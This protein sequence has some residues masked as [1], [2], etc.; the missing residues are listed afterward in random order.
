MRIEYRPE[1]DGLRT[2]AVLS[3]V[4]Y[5][6][7]FYRGENHLF[8][9]GFFGVDIF[10]VISGFLITSLILHE[11]DRTGRF[12][13]AHFYERRARRL[14]P[15]L[16]TVALV[17][18]P[19]SLKYLLPTQLL[20]FAKSL[21]ATLFFGS[22][23]YWN[24]TLQEYGAES[25]LIKPFL[26][27]WSLAI[28]EQYYI[29]FPLILM[30]VYR[31]WRRHTITLLSIG[32]LLSLH[33]ADWITTKDASF[34]FYMLISRFWELLT[35]GIL[36]NILYF[37]PKKENDELLKHTMPLLGLFLI[38]HSI[39]FINI[40]NN[41]PG[42]ITLIPVLGTVLIIWF[43]NKD[44]LVTK[45]LSSRLFVGI[46]LI[47]YSVYLWHYP[48]FAFGRI[49]DP[50]P[51][52]YDRVEWIVLTLIL[53]IMTYFFIEKYFRFSRKIT[54]KSLALF[55]VTSFLAI[56]C[57]S[58]YVIQKNGLESRFP[59]L[60]RIYGQNE[61]DNKKLQQESWDILKKLSNQNGY[62]VRYYKPYQEE[63]ETSDLWFTLGDTSKKIIIL[64][65]SH[66]KDLFNAFYQNRERY[67]GYEFA[68]FGIEDFTAKDIMASLTKSP[69]Y[70][71]A[72]IVLISHKF[73]YDLKSYLKNIGV[74]PNIIRQFKQD[75][76]KV[77]L[78]S[79][80]VEF[81]KYNGEPLF[82]GY[83]KKNAR[84]FSIDQLK[85]LFYTQRLNFIDNVNDELRKIAM[86]NSISYLD[87]YEYMC[88]TERKMCDGA[89]PDGFKAFYDGTHYTL[90]GAK[91]FGARI[92]ELK[93]LR[94]D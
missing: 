61:F 3:V 18:I 89:T 68:R 66:S 12:S 74:L 87:K 57:F 92:A 8:Q 56:L 32:M 54:I 43:S 76:K 24:I 27:T 46:G 7:E 45:L 64:G 77:I 21:I 5:H 34:S 80:T 82:D 51:S 86:Q 2:V 52:V 10:F 67:T 6:A 31:W 39:L 63:F 75:N 11:Y 13:I 29:I 85:T 42:F 71:A 40:D 55:A 26:H 59:D 16:L 25:S 88:H 17:S 41:H 1:I 81:E 44:D 15:A 47:S 90:M 84:K 14:L 4:L 38:I 93:W 69:N 49:K 62:S 91:H 83:I 19:F 23:F 37:H 50:T 22:N 73:G 53:S 48:I 70:Q 33:F 9:G 20:D 30:A 72:D 36:A 60:M 94:L 58:I 35:G 79:N 65:N 28:E 78:T